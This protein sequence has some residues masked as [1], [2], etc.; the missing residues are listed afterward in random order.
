VK[1]KHQRLSGNRRGRA[2]QETI[3]R[4]R[5]ELAAEQQR[6]AVAAAGADRTRAARQRLAAEVA[7]TGRRL[8]PREQAAANV[9]TAAVRAAAAVGDALAEIEAAERALTRFDDATIQQLRQTGSRFRLPGVHRGADERFVET[10]YRTKTGQKLD[11]N[12]K[13]SLE[14][15]IPDTVGRSLDDLRPYATAHPHDVSPQASWA[16][17]VAPWLRSP[18][19][20][21][22]AA[23]L[24]GDLGATTSGSPRM[25]GGDYPGPGLRRDAVLTTPWRH[26][27]L[28]VEPGDAADRSYWYHRS[29]WAQ[30]WRC[31]DPVPVPFALPAEHASGFPQAR[32]LPD[33]VDVRLPYPAMFAS[34]A[35]GWRVEA[36]HDGPLPADRV[37]QQLL[38]LHA[39]GQAARYRP[40]N[41]STYLTRLEA[42]GRTGR[43]ALPT[44]LEAVE[45]FGG[46]VEGLMLFSD[47]RG[48][49][50][51][52]FG[53]CIAVG[54]PSGLPIA[55]IVVPASRVAS[56]WGDQVGNVIA[57][58]ALSCWHEPLP[59]VVPQQR[60]QPGAPEPVTAPG[61]HVLNIDATS[62]SS[63]S[64]A[65]EGGSTRPHLRRGHWRR[66]DAHVPVDLTQWTWVRATTVN[67]I[68]ATQP[69]VY[70][71]T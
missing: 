68:P 62:P 14:K 60:R 55:R 56:K 24:R 33:G 32:P 13:V 17:A 46:V 15:W 47:E 34:L 69:P 59:A 70:V 21:D 52:E 50:D 12:R 16:F 28:I 42:L 31:G 7:V 45:L 64:P 40:G 30:Q 35:D 49:P 65:G 48:V 66:L 26:A 41:L 43:D 57:G 19:S 10:W 51:D 38:M 2:A 18:Q 3:A 67:G 58:V 1:G 53:W 63:A 54:H 37:V 23:G 20:A 4:L 44:P 9:V 11:T 36:R 61:V 39:R 27:P 29:A 8:R 71:L 6:A 25:P 22:D 5:A